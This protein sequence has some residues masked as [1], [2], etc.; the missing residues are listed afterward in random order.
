MLVGDRGMISLTLEGGKILANKR[1]YFVEIDDFKLKGDV[2]AVG[3]IDADH[4]I[5]IGDDVVITHK[6][7][8]KGVGVAMMNPDEMIESKKGVAVKVRHKT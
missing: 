6:N 8:L 3:V 4:D 1:K 2:F 5:R 7:I